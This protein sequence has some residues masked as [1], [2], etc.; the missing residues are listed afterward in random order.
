[1]KDVIYHVVWFWKGEDLANEM[2]VIG[3]EKAKSA[4]LQLYSNP[5]IEK[6]FYSEL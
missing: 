1:M 3:E 4:V 5:L 6:A 2:L